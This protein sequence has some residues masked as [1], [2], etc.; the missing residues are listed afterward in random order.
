MFERLRLF[1]IDGMRDII[2]GVCL[3][4]QREINIS[5]QE[6][7]TLPWRLVRTARLFIFEQ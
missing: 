1:L 6:I 4:H 7:G 5:E 3:F 2:F